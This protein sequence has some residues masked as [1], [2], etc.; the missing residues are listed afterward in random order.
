MPAKW[1]LADAAD[2]LVIKFDQKILGKF[3]NPLYKN[4]L[5][6]L[7][8]VGDEIFRLIDVNRAKILRLLDLDIGIKLIV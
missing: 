5:V 2:R 4:V 7:D 6:I 3:T 1:L 8:R